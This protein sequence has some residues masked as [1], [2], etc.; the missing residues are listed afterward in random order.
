MTELNRAVRSAVP[1]G[2][3]SSA[4]PFEIKPWMHVRRQMNWTVSLGTQLMKGHSER[5][6]SGG[7]EGRFHLKFSSRQNTVIK[8]H[9]AS[10][11]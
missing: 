4:C 11:P 3:A 10:Q 5:K 8:Q 9:G 2:W 1:P 7:E 6:S